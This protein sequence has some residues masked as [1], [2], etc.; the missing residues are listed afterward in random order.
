MRKPFIQTDEMLEDTELATTMGS[1]V[2]TPRD[3]WIPHP[4]GVSTATLYQQYQTTRKTKPLISSGR[5]H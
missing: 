5:C 3:N 4:A 1:R 2:T